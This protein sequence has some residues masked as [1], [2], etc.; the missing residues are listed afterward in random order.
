MMTDGLRESRDWDD[1][2]IAA[3]LASITRA[4]T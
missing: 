3:Y 1:D 2:Q 4:V